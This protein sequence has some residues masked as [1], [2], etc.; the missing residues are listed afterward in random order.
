MRHF[1]FSA[2]FLIANSSFTQKVLYTDVTVHVGNGTV[3]ENAIV[4]CDADRFVLI[5]NALTSSFKAKNWDTIVSLQGQHMYPSFVAT[6]TTLGLTEIDAVRATRD[7]DDVGEF[8]PHVRTQIAFNTESRVVETVRTNGVLLTQA[9]PRGG[10]VSGASSIMRLFAWNWEDATVLKDD[11]IHI[12]WPKSTQGG[13]WWAEPKPKKRNKNYA[14]EILK[15]MRFFELAK[16]YDSNEVPFDQRLEAMK[17]CFVGTKRVYIHANE[18]QQIHDVIDFV[19]AFKFP[20]PVIIGGYDAH[21]IG[22][23]LK[24]ANIPIMLDRIHG[25]PQIEDEATDLPYRIP[26]LLKEQGIK[27][28]LQGSGDMEA[29]N[30]RN[31]PFLAGTA[32]AYGLEEEA[33]VRSISLDPCEI[34]GIAA[35]YG[36]IEKGKKASFFV[37]VGNALDMMTNDVT[38]I[39]LDGVLRSTSNFQLELYK[40]YRDKYERQ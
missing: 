26:A 32:M 13:G 15:L 5:K 12:N 20:F 19:N 33:A 40:R 36:S 30:S 22:K 7:F 6:N 14:S 29:M 21:L 1:I 16:A 23:K 17:D 8:N 37:S 10:M 38:L 25:L 27:F 2:L 9:T 31:L 35:D 24:D 28:C 18:L 3:I 39:C 11:G 4:G 34:I